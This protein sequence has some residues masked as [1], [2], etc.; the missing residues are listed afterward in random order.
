MPVANITSARMSRREFETCIRFLKSIIFYPTRM[1]NLSSA[2]VATLVCEIADLRKADGAQIG[3][4][5]YESSRGRDALKGLINAAGVF[6]L[7][8]WEKLSPYEQTVRAVDLA[9]LKQV[10]E[11]GVDS[12]GLHEIANTTNSNRRADIVFV[13]GLSGSSHMTWRYGKLGGEGHFFW[14]A[15]LGE[16]LPECGIWTIGYPAGI[17]RLGKPGMIIAKRA[18]NVSQK[19]TNAELGGRPLIIIVHSLGGLVV[20][21]FI[22]DAQNLPDPDRKRLVASLRGIVFCGTPHRGS[23]FADAAGVLGKFFGGSQPHVNEMRA[24]S[25]ALD[26][27]HDEFIEWQRVHQV[28]V[29]SYAENISLKARIGWGASC[30][31]AWW[32]REPRQIQESPVTRCGTSTTII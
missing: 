25:E 15:E 16:D 11:N 20:K 7:A 1:A 22:V 6:D 3:K 13:H 28:P 29:E 2:A 17:T 14:P 21:S 10:L 32:F 19:L 26:I 30:S 27:L 5:Y 24:N 31:L 18:N 12:E 23:A 9:R 4:R 8:E